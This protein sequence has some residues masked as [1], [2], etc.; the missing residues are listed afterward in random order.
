MLRPLL[1]TVLVASVA[2]SLLAQVERPPTGTAGPA[3]MS[4]DAGC[5][6][7]VPYKAALNDVFASHG[8]F[9]RFFG[10][11]RTGDVQD[12][13]ADDLQAVL[14]DAASLLADLEALEP[15]PIYVVG[16]QG[17]YD[18][19]AFERDYLVFIGLNSAIAPN[20]TLATESLSMIHEGEVAAA[21][22]CPDEVAEAGGF[23][24]IDP[25][26][27]E[28]VIARDSERHLAMPVAGQRTRIAD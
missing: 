5:E 14:D 21:A 18:R 20:I 8:V 24:F 25:A 4:G 1:A 19:F 10:V 26:Q 6:Q 27:L 15:P 17:I 11:G 13:A 12:L 2:L 16:H 23:I 3:P 28:D 9:M 22:A 7:V